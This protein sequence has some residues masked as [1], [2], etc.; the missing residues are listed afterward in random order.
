[1][2]SRPL[3]IYHGGCFDGFTA[4]WLFSKVEPEADFHG[5]RYGVDPPDV[6]DRDVWIVDFSYPAVSMHEI[7]K[8]ARSLVWLDHHKTAAAYAHELDDV[9]GVTSVFDMER[10]GSLILL[11]MLTGYDLLD[12]RTA[13]DVAWL[14]EYIDDRDRWVLQLPETRAVAAWVAAQPMTFEAWD[15]LAMEG[16]EAA[17][18][19]GKAVQAYIEQYG[20]K[21]REHAR[22]ERI[23]GHRVPTINLPY[24]NCSEHV[25]ALLDAHPG[26][27]F[28]AGYF[29]RDDGRWQFSLRARPD[30]DVSEVAETFGGGGHAG[31][32]GFDVARLPWD[33]GVAER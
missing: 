32:A 25:G 19:S 14:V 22:F 16:L 28:A 10:C 17:V 18:R 30:F 4:S 33:G 21:A 7:A 29:R 23:A 26:V 2:P 5:A 24:M 3:F 20:R 27:P 12:G 15:W 9:R 8:D 1:M 31:A 6:A 13:Q 11:H